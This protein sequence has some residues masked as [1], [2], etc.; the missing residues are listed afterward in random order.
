MRK[1]AAQYIFPVSSAPLKKGIIILDDNGVVIKLVDTKGSLREEAGL[2]FYNGVIVPGFVNAHCHLELSHLKG[3]IDRGS[4]LGNFIGGVNKLRGASYKKIIEAAKNASH[5]M[6]R[7]G[8]A[9]V[10][11]ISNSNITL[12][13]KQGSNI[14]YHTFIEVFGFMPGRA[15]RAFSIAEGIYNEC[16]LMGLKSSISPHS[17]YSVSDSLFMLIKGHSEK[18]QG[19]VSIHNQESKGENMFYQNGTGEIASHLKNNIGLDISH[20]KPTGANSLPSILNKL[21]KS[22]NLLLAHNVF[23]SGD[24][25]KYLKESCHIENVFFVLCPNANIYINDI[26]PPVNLF[27][28]EGLNICFGTDSLASNSELSILSEMKTIQSAFNHIAFNELIKWATLCGAQALQLGNQLGSFEK[29]KN[30]G[31]V[32]LE[33]FD[34]VNMKLTT[35]TKARRIV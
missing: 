1:I 14:T 27:R 35:E 25:I 15:K 17:P 32:L 11:D 30:P 12:K 16:S 23:T 3:K 26:L 22:N 9:A 5:I 10:G 31:V 29:G 2:E 4:G 34:L 6:W 28:D 19:I 7:N 8:V 18:Y 24:D 21:P 20:W 13:I 33:K